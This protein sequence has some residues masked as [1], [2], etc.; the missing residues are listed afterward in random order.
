M[1]GFACLPVPVPEQLECRYLAVRN[2][3]LK[4]EQGRALLTE[5]RPPNMAEIDQQVVTTLQVRLGLSY[6]ACNMLVQLTTVLHDHDS[7]VL[8]LGPAKHSHAC[9]LCTHTSSLRPILARGCERCCCGMGMPASATDAQHQGV[10]S[11]AE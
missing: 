3:M 5:G 9:R 11:N 8:A 10:M 6:P 4:T 2:E 1:P 7:P